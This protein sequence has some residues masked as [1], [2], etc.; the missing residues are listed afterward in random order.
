MEHIHNH[1]IIV[2][3]VI[4]FLN[5]NQAHQPSLEEISKHVHLSKYHLQRVFHDWAGVTPKQF[6]QYLHLKGAHV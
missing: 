5:E 2:E 6:L 3:K 1:Y 4:K